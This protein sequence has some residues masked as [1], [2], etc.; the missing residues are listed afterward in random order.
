MPRSQ[1]HSVQQALKLAPSQLGARHLSVKER[2]P[3]QLCHAAVRVLRVGKTHKHLA[4]RESIGLVLVEPDDVN[5]AKA[6]L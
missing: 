6:L 5:V 2:S 4:E 1:I 3:V